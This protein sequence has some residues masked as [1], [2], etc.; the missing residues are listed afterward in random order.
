SELPGFTAEVPRAQVDRID[1]SVLVRLRNERAGML[2]EIECDIAPDLLEA[3]RSKIAYEERT[4]SS[5]LDAQSR[6]D[7]TKEERRGSLKSEYFIR[8]P[9]PPLQF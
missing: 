5:L 3:I 8:R 6:R 7:S 9:L 4:L 2:R 1:D